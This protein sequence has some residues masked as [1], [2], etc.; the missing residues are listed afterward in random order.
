LA[1]RTAYGLPP[2]CTSQAASAAAMIFTSTFGLDFCHLQAL[3]FAGQK[4][5]D[6]IVAL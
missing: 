5:D 1:E 2:S 3:V 4:I 6:K